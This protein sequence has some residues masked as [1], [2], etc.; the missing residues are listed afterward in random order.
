M[1]TVCSREKGCMCISVLR[2]AVSALHR[3]KYGKEAGS[4]QSQLTSLVHTHKPALGA[5]RKPLQASSQL[6]IL[7]G[8]LSEL[9]VEFII[10]CLLASTP[11]SACVSA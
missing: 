5:P 1:L 9:T 10:F 11:N 7:L 8:H 6:S 4:A 2:M 3:H